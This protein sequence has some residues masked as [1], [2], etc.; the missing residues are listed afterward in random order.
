[1]GCQGCL[2]LIP[3]KVQFQAPLLE[4]TPGQ[5]QNRTLRFQLGHPTLI[6]LLA[7]GQLR[8]VLAAQGIPLLTFFFE[9]LASGFQLGPP[10]LIFL[11]AGRQLRLILTVQGI[12]LPAFFFERPCGLFPVRPTGVDT[13]LAWRSVA[14]RSG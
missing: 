2:A 3:L 6:F 10:L 5:F 13:L 12:P 4:C 1:M 14:T 11:L 8:L 9:C 7:G